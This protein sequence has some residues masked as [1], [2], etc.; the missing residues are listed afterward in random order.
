MRLANLQAWVVTRIQARFKGR[1]MKRA[2]FVVMM[3]RR[4]EHE[5]VTKLQVCAPVGAGSQVTV[6]F[7]SPD[8]GCGDSLLSIVFYFC[9]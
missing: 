4:S 6:C 8:S 7:D 1:Q 9:S 5:V 3:Q 2:Y